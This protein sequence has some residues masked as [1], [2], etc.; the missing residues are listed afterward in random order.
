MIDPKPTTQSTTMNN[1]EQQPEPLAAILAE[2]RGNEFDEPHLD[3][4]GIIGARRL[5]RDWADRIEAA[6]QRFVADACAKCA[7]YNAATISLK[8]ALDLANTIANHGINANDLGDKASATIYA[9]CHEV[10]TVRGEDANIKQEVQRLRRELRDIRRAPGNAAA[11]R[12]ALERCNELFRF[13]DDNKSRLCHLARK[14]DEATRAAL[15]APARNC[16]RFQTAAEAVAAFAD[17]LRAWENAH[18]IHSEYPD[19]P[20]QV[21]AGAFAWLFAPAEGGDH[22]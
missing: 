14:A 2:M 8:A 18:G 20:V 3:R 12:E 11:M 6:V 10:R 7:H 15:A 19:H 16:D 4:D 9:L 22:A 21:P 1:T 17:H 13:D 5:A